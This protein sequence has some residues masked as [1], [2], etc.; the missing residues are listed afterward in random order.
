MWNFLK[1]DFKSNVKRMESSVVE[2]KQVHS[3]FFF[4]VPVLQVS[5]ELRAIS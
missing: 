5:G 3:D 1:Q 2:F 4:V